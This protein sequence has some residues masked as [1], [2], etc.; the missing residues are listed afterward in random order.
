MYINFWYVAGSADE[1]TEQPV[2]RRMLGLDFVLF[3]DAQGIARVLSNTCTH[4]GGSLAD[5][6]VIGDCIQ[7]PY[8][9]WEFDGDG[10]CQKIPSAGSNG[11]IPA[12]TR[13]D[14]YPTD[15]RYG[16]VF[17]F[18]GDL[19]ESERPPIYDIEEYGENGP[20]EGWATTLQKAEWPF[21][22]KRS[23]E[24]GIDI[25]HNEFVHPTHG[26]SGARDDY[27]MPAPKVELTEWGVDLRSSGKGR[28]APP[29]KDKKMR[30]ASG[31]HEDGIITG[32]GG[33][34]FGVSTLWTHIRPTP[35]MCINQYLFETPVDDSNTRLYLVNLR[36]FLLDSSDDERI[37]GRN[38][39]VMI[40][41]RDILAGVHPVQT[42]ESN[43]H[44]FF[45]G[46]DEP[47]AKFR[48]YL[49]DWQARGWRMDI[50]KIERDRKRVAY[51]IPSPARR[52][53]KGWILQSVPMMPGAVAAKHAR[54]VSK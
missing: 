21:D 29:L 11:K 25:A 51:A 15:E 26:F 14:A 52:E 10:K 42:P 31:R 12:R 53:K 50:D 1:F 48:E 13:V 19:P 2:K 22:Y 47:I 54:V 44:E 33:G 27:E 37:M 9:G 46:P 20:V 24:N 17:A 6:K 36:N 41:D 18:L 34:T 32:G 7:C 35:E 39:A 3:R 43:I 49:K 4:R 30:E 45:V 5:G 16:L 38:E 23:M 40:Q 28:L 8:H